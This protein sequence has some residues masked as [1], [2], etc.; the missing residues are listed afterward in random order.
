MC[1]NS[2]IAQSNMH[3]NLRSDRQAARRIDR[4]TLL[5][6]VVGSPPPS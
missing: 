2:K 5:E 3:D 4:R 1:Q 6:G